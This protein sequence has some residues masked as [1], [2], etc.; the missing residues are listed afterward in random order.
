MSLSEPAVSSSYLYTILHVLVLVVMLRVAVFWP[1]VFCTE[2][3]S[4]TFRIQETKCYA[5]TVACLQERTAS[6]KWKL[7]CCDDISGVIAGDVTVV[8]M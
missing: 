3:L 5:G 2:F 8:R 7:A 4:I 1:F 6:L